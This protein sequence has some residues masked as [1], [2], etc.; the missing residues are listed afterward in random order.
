MKS[1]EIPPR[2]K[3]EVVI[4]GG[5]VYPELA[6][7]VATELGVEAA[8]LNLQRHGNDEL[9]VRFLDSVRGKD[10][11][12]LQAHCSASGYST[13]EAIN[14]HQYLVN[15]AAGATARSVMAIA[16]Y[17]GHSRGDRKSKGREVAP[18][19]Y[20]VQCFEVAGQKT[21]FSMMSIDLHSP[22]TAQSLRTGNYELLTAQ[23]EIRRSVVQYL[24]ERIKD[25]VVVAPDSGAVKNNNRHAKE[26]S[27]ETGNDIEVIFMGKER[28]RDDSSLLSRAKAVVG[29]EGKICL[30]FDDMIDGGSTM[31]TAAETLMESGAASVVVGATHPILSRNAPEKL[32]NSEIEKVFLADTLPLD[33]AEKT[34]Q[35]KLEIVKIAPLLGRAVY[36]VVTDGSLS[37]LFDDQNH[38]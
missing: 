33:E 2:Q 34:M 14:E 35:D 23:P 19:D 13:E 7:E 9:Y 27:K 24:G 5:G 31:I 3:N 8:N 15:A 4:A 28:A 18:A 16:P 12:I 11:F 38:R 26:L 25:C 37:R 29:V 36:E 22:P 6:H 17:L 30:T 10:V 32:A 20:T 1:V 21:K